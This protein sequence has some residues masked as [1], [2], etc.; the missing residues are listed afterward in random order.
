MTTGEGSGGGTTA[1]NFLVTLEPNGSN[2]GGVSGKTVTV[3]FE[4]NDGTAVS[5]GS[6]SNDFASQT[7][8]VIFEPG[9]VEETVS[10]AVTADRVDEDN[11][12]FQ[13]ELTSATNGIIDDNVGV[14]TITD[15]DAAPEVI[16]EEPDRHPR[17]QHR[18]R[19]RRLQRP[20]GNPQHDE[21]HPEQP[22]DHR[23]LHDVR[24]R[25]RRPRPPTTSPFRPL[26]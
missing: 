22:H 1:F 14:G 9:D 6:F 3:N 21:P 20:S 10:I 23:R 11:E 4:T 24:R 7:G 15:D 17:R 12:A 16:V 19:L 2:T 13:V 5:T 8:T 25:R 26:P 18:N